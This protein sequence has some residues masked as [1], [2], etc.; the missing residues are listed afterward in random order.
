MILDLKISL[1]FQMKSLPLPGK[2]EDR[3][4]CGPKPTKEISLLS[5]GDDVGATNHLFHK[6]HLTYLTVDVHQI[7]FAWDLSMSIKLDAHSNIIG[8]YHRDDLRTFMW[9][10]ELKKGKRRVKKRELEYDLVWNIT[11]MQV[12]TFVRAI[13]PN[14][15]GPLTT[16]LAKERP[17][18]PDEMTYGESRSQALVKDIQ[19]S[20]RE[21]P[22]AAPIALPREPSHNGRTSEKTVGQDQRLDDILGP[23]GRQLVNDLSNDYQ[24]PRAQV[25]Q[26]TDHVQFAQPAASMANGRHIPQ[27]TRMTEPLGIAGPSRSA[28]H[29]DLGRMDESAEVSF[30]ANRDQLHN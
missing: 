27:T 11:E 25:A 17:L 14:P 23:S 24:R 22:H 9:P 18:G 6:A 5:M 21:T 28:P 8:S 29:G 13:F 1:L 3:I 20:A 15:T 26:M 30:H 2:T 12:K 4:R 16:Q 19:V 10:E 7:P